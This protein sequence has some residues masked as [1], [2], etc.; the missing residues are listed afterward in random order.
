MGTVELE[1]RV[2]MESRWRIG[3]KLHDAGEGVDDAVFHD[4]PAVTYT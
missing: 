3:D 1:V 4:R 2:E